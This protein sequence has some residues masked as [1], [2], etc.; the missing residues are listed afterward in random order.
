MS[1]FVCADH[2]SFRMLGD[3]CGPV[4][5]NFPSGR[6]EIFENN[7]REVHPQVGISRYHTV[8][9]IGKSGDVEF[10]AHS[11]VGQDDAVSGMLF[12]CSFK[13]CEVDWCPFAFV[14]DVGMELHGQIMLPGQ[15][16]DRVESRMVGHGCFTQGQSGE[17]I[18]AGKDFADTLP[19]S[20][21]PFEHA[22]DMADGVPVRGVESAQEGMN[23]FFRIVGQ[24]QP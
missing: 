19:Y 1:Y 17:V 6:D 15:F 5:I 18:M 21:I 9:F 24:G 22:F 20:G 12:Y 10:P 2:E 4:G 3:Q 7:P 13:F 16:E 11:S 14:A 23:S 8:D